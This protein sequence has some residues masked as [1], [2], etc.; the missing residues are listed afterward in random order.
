MAFE[1][2]DLIS[3]AIDSGV[4]S[5]EEQS[6]ILSGT[7]DLVSDIDLYRFQL[8]Q[9]QGITLDIDTVNA[10]NNTANFDSY[11]RVFDAD[12]NELTFNDDFSLDSEE[13]SL[14]SYI[15]FIA[16]QTGEYY[17]GVSSVA[18]GAYDP[19]T[20]DNVNQFQ[21]NFVAGDYYLEFNIVEVIPDEDADNTIAEAIGTEIGS[22]EAKSAVFSGEVETES[23]VDVYQFQ[24]ESGEGINLKIIAK[25]NDSNLDSF[26]R[27]FDAEGYEL[28]FDDN[29]SNNPGVDITT[30][31]TIAFAP[32]TPGEYFVGVS[33]AGNF[34]Y[35]SVNGDTNLNFSPNTGVSMG[36]YDL[37]LDVVEVV[38][39]EDPDNTFAEAVNSGVTSSGERSTVISEGID[40]ELD[41]DIYKVQLEEGDGLYL[42]INA[43]AIDSN[44]NSFLRLF[45]SEGNELTFDDNDVANFTED[46][47]P[48][49]AIA[50]VPETPGEYFVG[51][52]AS[53]NS[54][55]DALNDR[56]NFSPN[57]IS[58]FSTTGNYE[59]EIDLVKVIVDADPDNT[60]AEAI[61]SGVSSTE[62]RSKVLSGEVNPESDVDIY[63]FQ[64]DRGKRVTLDI[65]A[66]TIDSDLDSFL[67][68]FDSE[69]NELITN[70]DDTAAPDRG[71]SA[72]SL[73]EF[74]AASTGDYYVGVSSFANFSYDPI[75]GSNNF[76]ADIGSSTGNYDL[77]IDITD[78][79]N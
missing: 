30:D 43:A 77:V 72:D 23:D 36:S 71:T 5:S 59:L 54:D 73:V 29:S 69:G 53:G 20:G 63:K 60:I 31:S 47:S 25:A 16:N 26:L 19:R 1:T 48:D 46:F 61:D 21:E 55:Y 40:P 4:S 24:L 9:G 57:I 56:T 6:V 12:G 15:G 33:S 52:S 17:V 50:F 39:D 70:D 38:P 13:F 45:D 75:N 7:I 35:D 3:E 68:L 42:N 10:D 27:V 44:L 79:P 62:E 67:R 2:K 51:V 18:N 66:A 65:N 37:Q 49:S 64:L 74:T 32:E 8:N 41:A 78:S 58:P 14:D 22:S 76:T 34:D 11:L 28:A